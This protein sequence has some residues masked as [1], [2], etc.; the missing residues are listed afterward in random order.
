V[1]RRRR[2]RGPWT[3]LAR[4]ASDRTAPRAGP[5]FLVAAL[6]GLWFT[7]QATKPVP[8]PKR[9]AIPSFFAGWLTS[10]LV[11][12]HLLWQSVAT[13]VFV[14]RGALRATSGR[15]ALG[16]VAL[17]W[18]MM[19][20]LL[21]DARRAG[22]V[23]EDA[24]RQALGHDYREE[25]PESAESWDRLRV[26]GLTIPFYSSHP[27]VHRERNLV[28][29]RVG[30]TDLRVD[31]FRP[32]STDERRRPAVVYVHG[33]A[34]TLGFRDR[35]G[36]PLLTE[37]AARGWVGFLPAYRLSPTATY[38]D[39]LVDVKRAIAWIREH[40]DEY[41]VDPDHIVISGGSA[42]GHLA[43]MAALTAGDEDLQPGFE[44]ADTSVQA[45]VPFY[46]VYDVGAHV[47]GHVDDFE[48]FIARFIV[49]ADLDEEP[50]AWDLFRPMAQLR[51]EAP[52]FLVVH[53]ER[54]TLTSPG[55]ARRFARRLREVSA[56]PVGYAELPGGQHAFDVF[57]SVRSAHALRGVARFLTVTHERARRSS[58][59][60]HDRPEGATS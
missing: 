49:K 13:A 17:Q 6:T 23:M 14:R 9:R 15:V 29:A 60:R 39:H 47:E 57:P 59:Q 44:H 31:V 46:G 48:R 16:V 56:S 52:P 19:L 7:R 21:Q 38:P 30:A 58:G 18:L 10:E 50:K 20:R 26:R 37:M 45:C 8:L 27:T 33:G 24:L 11:P 36:G 32:T 41:G 5:G 25:L 12:H 54:D 55:E 1:G 34:W 53:G 51:R 42:G 40:A 35:Q 3:R 28:Y 4:L 43:S 22:G 2:R